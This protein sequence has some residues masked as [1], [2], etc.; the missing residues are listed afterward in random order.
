MAYAVTASTNN[1]DTTFVI[2]G[3]EYPKDLYMIEYGSYEV[4]SGTPED[5]DVGIVNKYTGAPLVPASPYTQYTDGTT[6]FT[7]LN[8]L[9]KHLVTNINL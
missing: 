7:S 6:A 4:N 9:I 5:V 1:P 3:L 2:N 8:A